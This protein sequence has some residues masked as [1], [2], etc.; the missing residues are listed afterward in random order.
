[1]RVKSV[2]IWFAW[3]MPLLAHHSTAAFD[4]TQPST[5]SGVVS[6]FLWANPHSYI[7]LDVASDKGVEHWRLEIEAANLLRRYGWTKDS[8]K[9]GDKISCMGARAKDPATLAQKCFTVEFPDGRKLMATP[10]GEPPEPSARHRS[11]H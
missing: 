6:K 7:D 3:V 1:M 4:M 11:D 9:T 5:V 2:A 10:A 8:L